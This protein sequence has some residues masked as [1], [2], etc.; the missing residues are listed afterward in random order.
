MDDAAERRV[1]IETRPRQRHEICR[2]EV[3]T[4]QTVLNPMNWALPFGSYRKDLSVRPI[5][6]LLS[7]L[8]LTAASFGYGAKLEY[9]EIVPD[10][11]DFV[12][13]WQME[14]EDEVREYELTR[15]TPYSNQQFVKVQGLVAH[16]TGVPYEFR[17]D[18]VYKSASDQLDYRLEVIYQNGL[19]EVVLTQS[20]NYTST[21]KRRTWGSI[22][23]MFQ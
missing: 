22:K 20:V 2:E 17:D 7:V 5:S 16:G 23:A 13:K 3:Y 4:P 6:V 14:T 9:F 10:G 11:R 18:Q 1:R 21:A 19:R 15:R 12:V 8:V